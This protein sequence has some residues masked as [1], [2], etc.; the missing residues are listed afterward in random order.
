[1]IKARKFLSLVLAVVICIA[2]FPANV[3]HAENSS[4]ATNPITVSD[5]TTNYAVSLTNLPRNDFCDTIYKA[6]LPADFKSVTVTWTVDGV[7]GGSGACWCETYGTENGSLT[8]PNHECDAPSFD[9]SSAVEADASVI[10]LT[11][12]SYGLI[13]QVGGSEET[14]VPIMVSDGTTNYAVSLT[15]L[16][17]NDF[18]DT[19]YKAVLPA[20]FK[21]VTV[22]W[23]VDGVAG[24]SGACWCETYG[25]ENG[26]LTVP[27][28]ECDAPS[29]DLSSAVEADASVIFLT[30]D[31]YGLILQVGG[32]GEK[33]DTPKQKHALSATA[34][35]IFSHR[36][37]SAGNRKGTI[38]FKDNDNHVIEEA[39]TGETVTV[40]AEP[41][42]DATFEF[43]FDHW[44]TSDISL[45]GD[46]KKSST[47]TF[48]MPDSDVNLHA[49]FKNI[50]TKVSWRAEPSTVTDVEFSFLSIKNEHSPDVFKT[51]TTQE[52]NISSWDWAE[53]YEF[54][55]WEVICDGNNVSKDPNYVTLFDVPLGSVL[56]GKFQRLSLKISGKEMEI[57]A[58]FKE[59][60]FASVTTTVNDSA[61]GTATAVVGTGTPAETLP[62]VYEDQTVTLTA[63]PGE[64]YTLDRW[65]VKDA[66]GTDIIVTKD[67]ENANQATFAMPGTGKDITAKAIF[68][69]D[70]DKASTEKV[71]SN[72]SLYSADGKTLIKA[73]DK[74]GTTFTI[75]LPEDQDTTN[76]ASFILKF[77]VS[78]YAAIRLNGADKDWPTDGKACNMTLD[79]PVTFVVTA[80]NGDKQEYTVVIKQEQKRSSDK[81]IT[82]VKLLNADKSV[83]ASGTLSGETWTIDLPGDI[84][85]T[86]LNKIGT[87]TDVFMQIDY[88]GAS[89][90]QEEGYDDAAG[91]AGKWSSGNVMCGIS[92]NSQAN[93]TVTAEDESTKNYVVKI[94]YTA[95]AASKPALS[96]GSAERTSDTAATV[97]FT[98]SAAGS[99]YYRVVASGAA[100]PEIPTTGS[101][102]SAKAGTNTISL[103]NLVAGARDIYIVVKGEG[104][105]VSDSLKVAIPAFGEEP[106]D[107][108]TGDFTIGVNCPPQG[109]KITTSRTRANQGDVI[110]VTATPD[111]GYQLVAGSLKFT[112]DVP[113]GESTVITDG[114]FTMPS[115]NVTVSCKWETVQTVVSG[116]TA[117]S[118]DGVQGVVDNAANTISV[119]MPYGTDVTKLIPIISG[120]N[121]A[122]IS[123]ASGEMVNFTNSVR[124][125][126]TLTD[127]TVKYY[128]VTVYV[129]EGTVADKMWDKLTDF[130][131][132]TPW[133]EYADHQVSTGRYPKYW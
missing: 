107:P 37:D 97:T 72:V 67:A 121:I 54:L 34:S 119:V 19:I 13:L 58:K 116:I 8:V 1:M 76:L 12:D 90:A 124:Y 28:H 7:A 123:P 43:V 78:D 110:T 109:G 46:E 80:E 105:E 126:V 6:V 42:N 99:Y 56:Y 100:E 36:P 86:L 45:T 104:G 83:I 102:T 106:T 71:L 2:S 62:V 68:K 113:G 35:L 127:G 81:E 50:G 33:P 103:T 27:N 39:L 77:T 49:D 26:S 52:A 57:T 74:A 14:E 89:V 3:V 47:L 40:V 24:G 44:T 60:H 96:N 101:G 10:F 69:V 41:K 61:M 132:Q 65:E 111:S 114:T 70:P 63:A 51:D 130:Y 15:N 16:P 128:T 17:R 115:C 120:N 30:L 23:T 48:T 85:Q 108:D 53:Q 38:T 133:W 117:F 131:D 20:D 129:Q 93:F 87:A 22:T 31:S 118:I 91:T 75:T 88:T 112:L 92:P 122:S 18:C 98:S 82:A 95:A 79:T 25:T 29:F 84:D 21:S 9:L 5:G 32:K 73:A 4:N 64:R 66:D 94:T 59:R 125:T 55:G 11:L